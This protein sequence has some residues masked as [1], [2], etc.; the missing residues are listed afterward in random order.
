MLVFISSQAEKIVQD[1]EKRWPVG[2]ERGRRV[3]G[4]AIGVGGIGDETNWFEWF[5]ATLR[6]EPNLQISSFIS[7]AYGLVDYPE[8]AFAKPPQGGMPFVHT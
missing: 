5:L 3:E 1:S 6:N 2:A 4:C 7:M 8:G